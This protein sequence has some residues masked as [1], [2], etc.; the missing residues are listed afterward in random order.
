M[1]QIM[2]RETRFFFSEIIRWIVLFILALLILLW[3]STLSEAIEREGVTLPDSM[4]IESHNLI[5]NGVGIRKATF[6]GFRVYVAGLYLAS[7]STDAKAI[8][9]SDTP[10]YLSMYFLRDVSKDDVVHAWEKGF[11]D[12]TPSHERFSSDLKTLTNAMPDMKVGDI[13][14]VTFFKD[15]AIVKHQKNAIAE[16]VS[17]G[18]SRALLAIWLGKNPPNEGLKKGLLGLAE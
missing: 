18:F 1:L 8:L 9:Q 12:N 17:N 15:R 16:V 10:K 4:S 3:S 13:L 6:L 7:S 14:E 2:V 11:A 5:L